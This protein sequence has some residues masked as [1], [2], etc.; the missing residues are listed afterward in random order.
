MATIVTPDTN[1]RWH[2][3]LIAAKWTYPGKRVGCPGVMKEIR[4]L[5]VRMHATR[6]VHLAGITTSRDGEF[7]AQVARH[8][9][10]D[11][12]GCLAGKRFVVLDGDS[13]FT[14]ESCGI[15]EGAGTEVVRTSFKARQGQLDAS[16]NASLSASRNS[17]IRSS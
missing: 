12:D 8:L 10:A 14:E 16:V 7:M 4:K 13:K 1:L 9:T 2:R 5:I 17:A 3:R 6:V 11:V 15:L